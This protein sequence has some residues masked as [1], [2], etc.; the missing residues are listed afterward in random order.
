MSGLGVLIASGEKGCETSA[1]GVPAYLL[2][3]TQ[4]FGDGLHVALQQRFR[5]VGLLAIHLRAGDKAFVRSIQGVHWPARQPLELVSE[6]LPFSFRQR[7]DELL[8]GSG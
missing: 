5:P 7:A 3:D 4:L 1:E 6:T 2:R 8:R